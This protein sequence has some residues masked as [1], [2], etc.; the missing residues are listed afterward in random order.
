MV[1]LFRLFSIYGTSRIR[2]MPRIC[3]P[4]PQTHQGCLLSS[5]CMAVAVC[6][7]CPRC[8][9][10][11][12]DTR[13]SVCGDAA[14][15][16][17]A[18]ERRTSERASGA[19]QTLTHNETGAS[20][21]GNQRASER[22]EREERASEQATTRVLPAEKKRPYTDLWRGAENQNTAKRA[23]QWVFAHKPSQGTQTDAPKPLGP[24]CSSRTRP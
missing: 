10:R 3:V 8:N 12:G 1:R 15:R 19:Q 11:W 22:A 4:P 9:A 17:R 6:W 21:C 13:V 24:I 16:E 5:I 2:E 14:V 18:S 23:A 7:G 20:V